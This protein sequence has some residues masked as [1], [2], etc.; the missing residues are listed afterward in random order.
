MRP[1]VFRSRVT[2]KQ[3]DARDVSPKQRDGDLNP[4]SPVLSRPFYPYGKTAP[5]LHR[6]KPSVSRCQ[7]RLRSRR[8]RRIDPSPHASGAHRTLSATP[9]LPCH[10]STTR[11]P[12]CRHAAWETTTLTTRTLSTTRTTTKTTA[13]TIKTPTNWFARGAR[14]VVDRRPCARP[15]AIIVKSDE[16]AGN[17]DMADDFRKDLL[18]KHPG[19]RRRRS[20]ASCRRADHRSPLPIGNSLTLNAAGSPSRCPR[21][22]ERRRSWATLMRSVPTSA[23]SALYLGGR[24]QD[25]CVPVTP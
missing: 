11:P 19:L 12:V 14:G 10:S 3:A 16:A 7:D 9:P 13:L 1:I 4:T 22:P 20:S 21:W 5:R 24:G 23:A 17:G 8:K 25:W 18:Q 6:R 15:K 2:V